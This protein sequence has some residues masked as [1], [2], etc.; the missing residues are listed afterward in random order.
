V[1]V[2]AA[3]DYSGAGSFVEQD[4][5]IN[6]RCGPF[7]G[8]QVW[9]R[10]D[11]RKEHI[12]GPNCVDGRGYSGHRISLEEMNGCRAV[13]CLLLKKIDWKPEPSD[14]DFELNSK[15]F[16]TGIGDG[17]PDLAPLTSLSPVRHVSAN[18]PTHNP[19]WGISSL[20]SIFL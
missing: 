5:D 3:W 18:L 10:E 8:C 14:Q 11:G 7:S 9:D 13:Q 1:Q 12:A 2:Q 15:V 4:E 16:L 17:S 20:N 6:G 19:T